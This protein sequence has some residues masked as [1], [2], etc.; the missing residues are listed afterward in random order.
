[1]A[2]GIFRF[3]E[4][5]FVTVADDE[6]P[7]RDFGGPDLNGV[8]SFTA[9]L[10]V[11]E[12]GVFT[13]DGATITTVADTLGPF[14]FFSGTVINDGGRVAFDGFLDDGGSG[15]FTGPDPVSDKVVALG[16]TILGEMV[17]SAQLCAEGLN[18]DG[19][20]AFLATLLD[21]RSGVFTA[22]PRRSR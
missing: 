5:T 14:S 13:A 4:A 18:N 22:T 10:D 17:I 3:D 16:D 6:G 19:E 21:G 8:V 2:P 11:V 1:M 9:T 12:S 20:I 7:F 15:I